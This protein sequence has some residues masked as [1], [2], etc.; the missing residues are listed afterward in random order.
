[1]KIFHISDLHIGKQLHLY[2]IAEIQ[3]DVLEQIVEAARRERPDAVV[4]AGD[5]YDRAAPSGEAFRLFDTFLNALGALEP[6]PAVMIISGNHDSG[7]RLKFASSFLERHRIHIA[8]ILPEREEEHLKKIV[9]TD[10]EGEVSFYLLPFV[11]PADARNLFG[12]SR[13]IRTYDDAVAAMLEREDIDYSRRNVLAAH[14][15]FVAGGVG[16]ECR[17]SELKYISVGGI[18]SV[19]VRHVERF[20]YVALGHIHTA[21]KIGGEHIRY[22]GT[23]LKY[24]VSEAADR[25][26]ITVAELGKK[27]ESPKISFLPLTMKRD[28]RKLR[29]TLEDVI[30][31]SDSE[32]KDAYVS[33]TLTDEKV[34]FR[35]RE[36]L[37]EFYS[38]IVEILVDNVR[39]RALLH[40]DGPEQEESSP[41]VLFD[42]FYREMNGQPMS[43]VEEAVLCD[44]VDK[45]RERLGR[46]EL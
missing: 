9:L 29:G 18:D 24:S 43:D 23:P 46:S 4:I 19:D 39:T 35:P 40:S 10:D 2:D 31:M 36:R 34:L 42:E 20:D 26:G 7:L 30:A 3:Q 33:I 13:E 1:M 27:G 37:E 25:K 41:L 11:R 21:Q 6:Q 17:D 28:V 45:V 32:L 44:C 22:S 38:H 8:A 15:F 12:D 5:I 14:Q 16:P